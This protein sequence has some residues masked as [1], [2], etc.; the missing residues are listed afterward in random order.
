MMDVEYAAVALQALLLCFKLH[1]F[2]DGCRVIHGGGDV[3][4]TG[5]VRR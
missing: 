4:T 2:Q 5:H 3:A 1:E